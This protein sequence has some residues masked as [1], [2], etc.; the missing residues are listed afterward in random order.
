MLWAWHHPCH[1]TPG[2]LPSA[3]RASLRLFKIA[4]GDSVERLDFA[5]AA[6]VQRILDHIG[7][8]STPPRIS[9]CRGSPDW[10]GMVQPVFLDEVV[11]PEPEYPVDQTVGW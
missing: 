10:E 3:L 11:Q 1:V 2:F 5:E 9:P 7:E 8:S 6:S 4:P